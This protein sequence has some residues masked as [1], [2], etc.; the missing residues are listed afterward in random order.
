MARHQRPARAALFEGLEVGGVEPVFAQAVIAAVQVA[1]LQ[2]GLALQ[3]LDEV[4][5]PVQ[6]A[7][8]AF[9]SGVLARAH[10]VAGGV[11]G[12]PQVG[13]A[14]GGGLHHLAHAQATERQVGRQA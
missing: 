5:M 2:L 10:G 4:A 7:E 13:H 14:G 3:L 1:P 6:A 12:G 11:H 9:E 8:E